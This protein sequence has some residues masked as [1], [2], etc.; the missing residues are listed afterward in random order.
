MATAASAA[1]NLRA[2]LLT[3]DFFLG[4]V[5]ATTLTKLIF[6]L[7]EVQSSNV[8]V[9]KATADVLLILV[10][11]L[12]L[13]QSTTVP[14]V[15]DNDSYDRISLC[16]RVIS[17]VDVGMRT[18]W[19]KLCRESFVKMIADKHHREMEETKAIAQELYAQPDDLIDFYHL[20]SRK[21]SERRVQYATETLINC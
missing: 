19:L 11:M 2:M 18:V 3:G 10:S 16:I 21:V 12:R 14:H 4:A 5:V 17:S 13:G 15:I 8:A 6:H 9:N 1:G 20:K 7:K